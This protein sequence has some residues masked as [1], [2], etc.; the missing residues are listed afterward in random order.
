MLDHL[1]R[2]PILFRIHNY[3]NKHRSR[4]SAYEV[5]LAIFFRERARGAQIDVL[6]P[7]S[8]HPES[9]TAAL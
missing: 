8:Y 5:V 7:H 3:R 4:A 9:K 2:S 1:G 6:V